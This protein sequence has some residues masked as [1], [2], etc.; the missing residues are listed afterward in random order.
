M[1]I[2]CSCCGAHYEFRYSASNVLRVVYN[3]G[4]GSYGAVLYCPEC[5]ATWGERN[6]GRPKPGPENTIN[7]IDDLHQR[8]KR[9]YRP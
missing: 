9:R 4:W 5:S 1:K 6:K 3:L 2:S 7:V 8:S